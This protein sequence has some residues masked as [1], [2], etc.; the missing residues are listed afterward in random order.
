MHIGND[1]EPALFTDVPQRPEV[2]A[3][4]MHDSGSQA[5]RVEVIVKD[6]VNDPCPRRSAGAKEKRSAFAFSI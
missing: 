1:N 4:E 5:S 6:E 2:S 3:I